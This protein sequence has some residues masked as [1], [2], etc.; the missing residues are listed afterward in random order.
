MIK[1]FTTEPLSVTGVPGQTIEAEEDAL[2][3]GNGL[4]TTLTDLLIW[5][6][7]F[8]SFAVTEYNVEA[9]GVAVTLAPVD[10]D[11]DAEGDH[12]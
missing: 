10:A 12:E 3:I 5:H 1:S 7:V 9:E 8:A 11:N 4:T 6:P 2:T